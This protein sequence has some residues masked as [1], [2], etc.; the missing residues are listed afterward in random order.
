MF[1]LFLF[2]CD[3]D[4]VEEGSVVVCLDGD[5]AP[6][7]NDVDLDVTGTVVGQSEGGDCLVDLTIEQADGTLASIGWT[8]L[9]GE[10]NDLTP[11]FNVAEGDQVSFTYRYRMV[12]GD[13]AGFVL[14]DAEGEVI[15]AADE[16]AWDNALEE[17]DVPGLAVSPGE[18]VATEAT[19]CEPLEGHTLIFE[20]DNTVEIE[21]VASDTVTVGGADFTAYA[22]RATSWGEGTGCDVSDTTSVYAWAI[23]R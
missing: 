4:P 2:A 3:L 15:A 18:V 5:A 10:G 20:G 7:G 6:V 13:V 1:T 12:W 22:L 8:L 19:E 23:N 9:D 16:G 11:D 14:R 21:P 17:G